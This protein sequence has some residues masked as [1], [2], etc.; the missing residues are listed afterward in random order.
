M[1]RPTSGGTVGPRGTGGGAG[2]EW[3]IVA[4]AGGVLLASTAAWAAGGLAFAL[5]GDAAARP[6]KWRLLGIADLGRVE[7]AWPGTPAWLVWALFTAQ[8]AGIAAAGAWAARRYS[9]RR[10]A[11]AP[12]YASLGRVGDVARLSPQAAAKTALRVR[13]SLADTG[14]SW[15]DVPDSDRGPTLG[16]LLPSGPRL[17]ATVEDVVL[18][19]A[20]PRCGKTTS[21]AV[22]IVLSSPGSVVACS[23]KADLYL[24]TVGARTKIGQVWVGDFQAVTHTEQS[25]WWNP[26]RSVRTMDDAVRL[27][28][29]FILAVADDHDREVWGPAANELLSNLVFAAAK[30]NLT[31]LDVYRW[32][33]DESTEEPRRL[34]MEA[35]EAEAAISLQGA[36]GLHTETRG[37]VYFTARSA[38]SSLRDKTIGRWVTPPADKKIREFVP[39]EFVASGTETLYLL[40][41]NVKGG[42]SAAAIVA[43][44][45][46]E[47]RVAAERAGERGGGRID[48]P[49]MLVLDEVANICRIADLPE[50]YSHLGSRSIIPVA[51]LQSYPQG[52]RVW[53]QGGMKELWN[54]A[55]VKVVGSGVDDPDF[56]ETMS[57]LIGDHYVDHRSRSYG[58]GGASSSQA[59]H[60]ERIM[61]PAEIRAMPRDQAI[62]LATA[63]RPA[64]I[65]LQPWYSGPRAAEI[66][67]ATREATEALT[68]RAG[69]SQ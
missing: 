28:G 29:G 48:P 47:V 67:Q 13:P 66:G 55:T 33:F 68:A 7:R 49:L 24:S 5:F 41:K 43:A 8:L 61:S 9:R 19:I 60:L 18:V 1:S 3:G 16:R 20:P 6:A 62:L 39:D 14:M 23:N 52:E 40:S 63:S 10:R 57:K 17:H 65:R 38:C 32:L 2:L 56:A 34:L 59:P 36:Q 51:I 50:Q 31:L 42:T 30:G 27:A 44:L 26:L 46:T 21:F 37:S 11:G 53:G 35:G 69:A 4:A 54:A 22:P 15:R 64:L 25:W 58:P 12:V 45:T